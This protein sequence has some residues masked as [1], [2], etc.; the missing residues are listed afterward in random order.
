MDALK[1]Q[2]C[3][4]RL[5][6]DVE[7]AVLTR[8]GSYD[9][10]MAA[11]VGSGRRKSLRKRHKRL[12]QM[13]QITMRSVTQ[14][15]ELKHAVDEFLRLEKS[16]WKGRRGTAFASH[17][18]T[19]A[20]AHAMFAPDG[21]E[22][23][24]RADI[25]E[26]DGRAI[27]VSLA[28][29]SGRRAHMVKAAYDESFRAYAPGLLLDTEITRAFLHGDE[30]LELDSAST[31][32]CVLEDLWIDRVRIADVLVITDKRLSEAAIDRLLKREHMRRAAVVHFKTWVHKLQ[33]L[34]GAFIAKLRRSSPA[35]S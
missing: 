25:L 32:G 31:P 4:I 19:L 30:L 11:H 23:A 29:V 9:A 34:R 5:I 24:V 3:R 15:D 21:H 10:Y 27:A 22:P 13:G 6:T 35:S 18:H 14:G 26:F 33:K 2:G 1:Q 20:M 8:H 7:R 16:G 28:L 17:S 12:S